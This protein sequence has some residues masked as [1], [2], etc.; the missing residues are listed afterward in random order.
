MRRSA[1][2]TFTQRTLHVPNV[3]KTRLF[4]HHKPFPL[5]IKT[6][7]DLLMARRKRARLS[8]K[9]FAAKTGIRMHWLRRWEFDRCQPPQKEWD[10]LRKFIKLPSTPVL[11]FT[12]SEKTL[13]VSRTIGQ[14]L[15]QRR[16]GLRLCLA[17]AAPRMGVATP[18]LGLWE[19][20]KVFPK[21]CYHTQIMTYLGYDPFPK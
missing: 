16:L 19:L 6:I 9:Q 3:T 10:R 2:L 14:H 11:T 17:E 4:Y 5:E 21:P 13:N 1:L 8:H 20:D 15:R 12:Q 18:T 7:G